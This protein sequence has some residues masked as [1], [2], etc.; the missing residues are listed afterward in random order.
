MGTMLPMSP[1]LE[2]TLAHSGAEEFVSRMRSGGRTH[3][4]KLLDALLEVSD[5]GMEEDVRHRVAEL[6][7]GRRE[8]LLWKTRHADGDTR[9]TRHRP[10][11]SD[12]ADGRRR[13]G[14]SRAHPAEKERG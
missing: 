9:A 3:R 12:P 14:R 10:D 7:A 6:P 2:D 13:A 1:G 4:A 8:A 5:E 11:R